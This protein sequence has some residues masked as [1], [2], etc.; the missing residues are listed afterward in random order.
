MF[1]SLFGK[2]KRYE[3]VRIEVAAS[4]GSYFENKPDTVKSETVSAILMN[5]NIPMS[6]AEGLANGL[7]LQMNRLYTYGKN[8]F[9][10]K[11]PTANFKYYGINYSEVLAQLR[12]EEG[13]NISLDYAVQDIGIHNI[14]L[15]RYLVN[16]LE[17]GSNNKINKLPSVLL[18]RR[19][20]IL[21]N[22]ANGN[23]F[24]NLST[25]N[26]K[27]ESNHVST[28]YEDE[29]EITT[30][31]TVKVK[32]V[33]N[34][35]S[36]IKNVSSFFEGYLNNANI[37]FRT[38]RVVTGRNTSTN[39]DVPDYYNY[40]YQYGYNAE[41]LNFY[42]ITL[43][44]ESTT[45]CIENGEIVN[46]STDVEL[47]TFIDTDYKYVTGSGTENESIKITNTDN[48][49][50]LSLRFVLPN[51][52]PRLKSWNLTT[53]TYSKFLG[54]Q[55]KQ[56]GQGF[57]PIV[58]IQN[59]RTFITNNTNT[60][61]YITSKKL[62]KK[63]GIKL[64]TLSNSIANSPDSSFLDWV[65]MMWGVPIQS[66]NEIVNEYL[67]D[68]FKYLRNSSN[69]TNT[70]FQN[71]FNSNVDVLSD[72]EKLQLGFSLGD[73]ILG[74]SDRTPNRNVLEIREST[75]KVDLSYNY[76]AR[77]IKSGSVGSVGKITKQVI[78][79]NNLI[80]RRSV[81]SSNNIEVSNSELVFR[82]QISSS[83][84]EEVRVHGL[85]HVN[86]IY[87]GHN[88]ETDLNDS[89]TDLEN[90]LIIPL[91]KPII[92]KYP[93]I[94]KDRLF[95]AGTT[96]IFNSYEEQ[97]IVYYKRSGGFFRFLVA[98]IAIGF[99][100]WTGGAS[101]AALKLAASKGASVLFAYIMKQVLIS[102]A[103][104]FGTKL[105]VKT[106]G[107]KNSLYLAAILI[108]VGTAAAFKFGATNKLPFAE[109]YAM[110]GNGLVSNVRPSVQDELKFLEDTM[111][112]WLQEAK[113]SLMF[114]KEVED[115][116][117]VEKILDPFIFIGLEP[118]YIPGEQPDDYYNRTVHS[119]NTAYES[120][121]AVSNYVDIML[122]L[123]ELKDTEFLQE[124]G[125]YE[126]V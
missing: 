36:E 22:L 96:L 92:D 9:I 88:V 119:G 60:S 111:D 62:L 51:G 11:L 101:L 17:V 10:H 122:K 72:S 41:I 105:L 64:D 49:P 99:A 26:V 3:E 100:I 30:T 86:Y 70:E 56:M 1:G 40:Y 63:I 8:E 98:A 20:L 59:N 102:L 110:V 14:G 66:N 81:F 112:Q 34:L 24:S 52:K 67:M 118:F 35:T 50:Y 69:Y 61:E 38:D 126:P 121:E 43:E 73:N 57:Y 114:L 47:N 97:V 23:H 91:Y 78:K 87:K 18:N 16:S 113:E 84:F 76:I 85:L 95:N 65:Y 115:E 48:I 2:K 83:Q 7:G 53:S 116:L 58:R 15:Q 104:Q 75:Y 93:L 77:E 45:Q 90:N 5:E 13:Q 32:K 37:S 106:L 80:F 54:N 12:R 42:Q 31:T 29:K 33:V 55:T 28:L 39:I 94:K 79:R 124:D 6:I 19:Q 27:Y 117:N 108:V 125:N 123:P 44:I 103:I 109:H 120:I 74:F 71:W 68:F 82:K 89:V 4:S 107:D 46:E 21:N 25:F